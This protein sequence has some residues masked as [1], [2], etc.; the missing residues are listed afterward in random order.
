M[1]SSNSYR[2]ERRTALV[3][4]ELERFNFDIVALSETRRA[5]EGQLREDQG[6][7]TFFWKGLNED[8]PRIHGV[9]FAIRN[10]LLPKLKEQPVGINERLMTLRIE[11]TRNQHATVISAYAPTLMADDVD[12]ETFYAQLETVLSSVPRNDQ[13]ILLGDFNARVGWDHN[14]WKGTIGKEGVGNS[15]ENGILL[16]T[17][18]TEHNLV[19]TNTL[20]RQKK[21]A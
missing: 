13:L 17:K 2:P 8:Q 16:L 9:G 18:C 14:V 1:D 11:L 6:Q 4:R 19:I 7:F 20:F 12:K 10:S 5:G 21:Q 3:A 15:N